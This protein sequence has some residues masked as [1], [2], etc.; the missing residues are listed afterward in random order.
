MNDMGAAGIDA[1]PARVD[2]AVAGAIGE[3]RIVGAV[4]LVAK[5]GRIVCENAAGFNDREAGTSMTR[6]AIFRLASLTKPVV[7]ATALAQSDLGLYDLDTPVTRFLPTFRPKLADGSEPVVTV[8]HLLTHTAGLRYR[9]GDEPGG[10][11]HRADVS[12]GLDQ[13]GLPLEENLGRI[14][15]VPLAF[16]PGSAWLYSLAI[17]VLGG[18]V[19]KAHG[20][21]LAGAVEAHVTGPLAMRDTGFAVTD[22]KRLAVAYADA[23]PE[24]VRMADTH[25]VPIAGTDRVLVFHPDRILHP[26]SYQSGGGG[27]AGTADDFLN[28]LEALRT[29]GAPILRPETVAL[30]SR[31]QIGNLP[32]EEPGDIGWRFGFLSAVLADPK[33]AAVPHAPGTLQWGGVYG[34]TWFIDPGAGL[35][36]VILSNTAIEGCLGKFPGEVRDAIYG[37]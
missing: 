22:L 7:A 26:G 15:S 17:D 23:S 10:D 28:L 36:A 9:F 21:T 34:H 5:D 33:A 27:M 3:N 11:Y 13:P 6:D 24:P 16:A 31:N 1:M 2:R 29:G 19:A 37:V 32:R 4:V 12:D 25:S 14:A 8:R 20:G 18:M 30:A 35:S